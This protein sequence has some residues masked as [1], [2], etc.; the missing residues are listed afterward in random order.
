MKKTTFFSCYH[1]ELVESILS[2]KKE[3][4]FHSEFKS[5]VNLKVDGELIYISYPYFQVP[6]FGLMLEKSDMDVI[7]PKLSKAKLS[8]VNGE[9]L[10]NDEKVS[11][12]DSKRVKTHIDSTSINHSVATEVFS[13][14]LSE[15]IIEEMATEKSISQL[16]SLLL[17][18][19]Q[20]LTPSGDDFI[21][22]LLAL[23]SRIKFL[24][25]SVYD[26]VQQGIDERKTTDVSIAYL[27]SSLSHQFSSSIVALIESLE[28]KKKLIG[29]LEMLSD[30]GHTSGRD[31][32]T[33]IYYGL[34]LLDQ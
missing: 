2:D 15:S 17:G 8:A 22:G 10:I 28:D 32:I 25:D 1:G 4:I 29:N 7:K 33:G 5:G 24:P 21:V 6:P 27:T 30:M 13:D 23:N 34:K 14:Y 26:V 19:G 16:V 3:V 12:S 9:L 20:G 11:I 18:R 31:T